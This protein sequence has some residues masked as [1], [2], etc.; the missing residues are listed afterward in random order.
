MNLLI[1]GSST[2]IGRVLVAQLS[3]SDHELRLTSIVPYET[4]NAVVCS[5]EHDETTDKLVSGID[6]IINIGYQDKVEMPVTL[7]LDYYTRR[8]YNLLW[9]ASNA[10]IER[11][12]NLSTLRLMAEYEENLVVTENWRSKPLASDINLLCAHLVE[13]ICKEFARDRKFNVVNMRL[14]WPL[15]DRLNSRPGEEAGNAAI[16][17][18]D[19]VRAVLLALNANINPWQDIHIQTA[20]PNQR[21]NT[22]KASELLGF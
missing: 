16:Y 15:V 14:G 11:V 22:A 19:L 9:A 10:G 2:A 12:I 5:L 20:V 3:K 17:S 18:E 21:Y 4:Q 13:I 7:Q 1:N 6:A 8:T